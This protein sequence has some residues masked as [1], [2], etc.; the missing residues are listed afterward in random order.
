MDKKLQNLASIQKLI[1]DVQCNG[2]L[3]NFQFRIEEYKEVPYLQI[4][5][6]APCIN[7][8]DVELQYCRKW[9][10]QYT[11]CDSEVIR[12]AF[13]AALAAFKHECEESF[14]YKGQ[15]IYS[16]HTN[17][18]ELLAMREH[19]SYVDDER[20]STDQTK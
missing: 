9:I 7:T 2:M 8:G 12:T 6:R 13:T 1:S 15:L 5:F 19:D 10:L 14:Q 18:H 20:Q 11:M 17:V 16:P 4:V 3:G